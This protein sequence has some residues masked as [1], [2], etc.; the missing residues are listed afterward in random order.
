MRN[1]SLTPLVRK[2]PTLQTAADP[3]RQFLIPRIAAAC[4]LVGCTGLCS[5]NPMLT[6]FGSLVSAALFTLLWR[7]GEPPVLL[8][9]ATFQWMQAFTPVVSADF[10]GLRLAERFGGA[11]IETAAWLSL[12]GVLCL[13]TGMRFFASRQPAR[14]AGRVSSLANGLDG[15]KL[16]LAYIAGMFLAVG[17]HYLGSQIAAARQLLTVVALIKWIPLFLLGW[18]TFQHRRA[19]SW[20]AVAVGCELVLG[21][22]G[23]FSGFKS[24]LFLLLVVLAGAAVR[25]TTLPWP[26]ILGISGLALGLCVTWQA[27]K[28]DYRKFLNRGSGQQEVVVSFSARFAHLTDLVAGLNSQRLVDGALEGVYRLGYLDFFAYSI[29]NVPSRV[30]YQDGDLWFGAIKHVFMPRA[31][32]P[33]KKVTDDSARTNRFTFRN[34]AG[35]D[36]G[37]SIGIG[38]MGESYIDFGPIGMFVPIFLLGVY[39]GWLYRWFVRRA[40]NPLLGMAVATALLL[41]SAPL[42]ETS[43]VKLVGGFTAGF[44]ELA[45]LQAIVGTRF[46]GLVCRVRGE[47][48]RS[49]SAATVRA[50]LYRLE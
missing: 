6:F 40:A 48:H 33:E 50:P 36:K 47:P 10:E 14:K 28:I 45:V 35:A 11:E 39:S 15:R 9:I 29:R 27:V 46:W 37:T 16:L 7:T 22:S 24:V 2:M 13:A 12:L 18:T 25:S 8:F 26:R 41:F 49:R 30:P 4:F 34:V 32:F 38:Y 3:V 44:L 42:L 31:L 1:R 5:P 21:F 43:N 19:Y 17:A 20:L 23:F